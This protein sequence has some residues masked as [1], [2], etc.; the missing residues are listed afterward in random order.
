MSGMLLTL[1]PCP[2][3]IPAQLRTHQC[4]KAFSDSP[5][6]ARLGALGQDLLFDVCLPPEG[7]AHQGRTTPD[8]GT[9]VPPASNAAPCIPEECLNKAT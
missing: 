5:D 1:L 9:A 3:L 7:A 8:L 4:K 2:P 6:G